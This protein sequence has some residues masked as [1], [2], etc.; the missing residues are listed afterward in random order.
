MTNSAD[1]IILGSNDSF[2]VG[3][4]TTTVNNW[5]DLFYMSGTV[6]DLSVSSPNTIT[7]SNVHVNASPLS[8][9][10]NGSRLTNITFTATSTTNPDIVVNAT[11]DRVI[12]PHSVTLEK[13]HPD[14]FKNMV[15]IIPLIALVV[16][17]AGAASMIYLK[18][19][20]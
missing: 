19:K 4:G 16:L 12:V 9:Y 7:V 10:V 18:G 8:G 17:V 11:Y 1:T 13:D 20:E 14:T 15:R 2:I 5:Y 6:E 3:N